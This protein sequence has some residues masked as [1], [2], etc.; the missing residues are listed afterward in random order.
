MLVLLGG[1]AGIS[2]VAADILDC[3]DM[4]CALL[5]FLGGK[6]GGLV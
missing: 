2:P 4:D 6:T 3:D 5:V 1:N